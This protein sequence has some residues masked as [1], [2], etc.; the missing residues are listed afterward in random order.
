MWNHS[1]EDLSVV[2][3][4]RS[5]DVYTWSFPRWQ[6]KRMSLREMIGRPLRKFAVTVVLPLLHVFCSAAGESFS[7]LR[8]ERLRDHSD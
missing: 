2:L 3:A 8:H 6:M 1:S 4:W 7:P 5:G